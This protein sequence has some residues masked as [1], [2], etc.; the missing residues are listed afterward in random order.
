M[1]LAGFQ[2]EVEVDDVSSQYADVSN[3]ESYSRPT[4]VNLRTSYDWKDWS[5]W[6]HVMNLTDQKYASYV[7]GEAGAVDYYSGRPRTFFAGLSYTWGR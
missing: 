7:S 4:L 6:A 1:P 3:V 5:F 2:A